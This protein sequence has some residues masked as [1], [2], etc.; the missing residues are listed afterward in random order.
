MCNTWV[1]FERITSL[2]DQSERR[3]LNSLM[4]GISSFL[5]R[6][7]YSENVKQIAKYL[8]LCDKSLEYMRR[9]LE[10]DKI[11]LGCKECVI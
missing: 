5:S 2:G 9:I 6:F 8:P 1:Y 11:N 10:P 7:R 4:L 3:S